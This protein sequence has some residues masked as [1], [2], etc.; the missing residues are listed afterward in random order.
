MKEK[1]NLD[2][3]YGDVAKMVCY[4]QNAMRA[5]GKTEE[6]VHYFYECAM[7]TSRDNFIC[8][9]FSEINTLNEEIKSNEIK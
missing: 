6:E 4:V 7:A 1:Y 3:V 5:E 2:N 8:S 9:C